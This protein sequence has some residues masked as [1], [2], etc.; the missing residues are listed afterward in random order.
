MYIYAYTQEL[1]LAKPTYIHT[2]SMLDDDVHIMYIRTYIHT[3]IRIYVH[4]CIN[5]GTGT[6]KDYIPAC[7]YI[8]ART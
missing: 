7:A 8:Y 5:T 4:I 1:E 6:C 2:S 3:H